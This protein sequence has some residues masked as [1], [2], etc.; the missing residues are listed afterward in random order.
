MNNEMV[1][2]LSVEKNETGN[3]T[4][5]YKGLMG[6]VDAAAILTRAANR[7]LTIPFSWP[8]KS[9]KHD[10]TQFMT[11]SEPFRTL[12]FLGVC[13]KHPGPPV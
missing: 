9:Q 2:S 6:F 1:A 3:T 8:Y 11:N 13:M 5:S 12:S 10:V 7:K 4:S